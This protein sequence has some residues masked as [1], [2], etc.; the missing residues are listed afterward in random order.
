MAALFAICT[1]RLPPT[2]RVLAPLFYRRTAAIAGGLPHGV[3]RRKQCGQGGKA[4]VAV[5]VASEQVGE[6]RIVTEQ[7]P[8]QGRI[9]IV[10]VPDFV[11]TTDHLPKPSTPGPCLAFT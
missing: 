8:L 2:N 7:L 9:G 1:S 6:Y 5:R 3:T 11:R 10:P 4:G